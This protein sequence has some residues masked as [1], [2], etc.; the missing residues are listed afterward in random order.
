MNEVL[1]EYIWKDFRESNLSKY[2]KYFDSWVDNLTETQIYFWNL[3][4]EGRIC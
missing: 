4:M 1:R 2:Y 3:R